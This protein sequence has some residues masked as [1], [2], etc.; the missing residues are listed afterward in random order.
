MLRMREA[1]D[2][3]QYGRV[4]PGV[5]NAS[6]HLLPH[7]NSFSFEMVKDTAGCRVL[8]R[9]YYCRRIEHE[10]FVLESKWPFIMR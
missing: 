3:L 6:G 7:S 5:M 4:S 1:A 8:N 2:G 10:Y 9:N